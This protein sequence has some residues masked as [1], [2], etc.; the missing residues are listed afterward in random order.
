MALHAGA[1]CEG[2]AAVLTQHHVG[3][4]GF[5]REVAEELLDLVGVQAEPVPALQ[6]VKSSRAAP[7]VERKPVRE[8]LVFPRREDGP[9]AAFTQQMALF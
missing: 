9:D 2:V 8:P 5:E 4:P 3:F 7:K 1:T 6:L